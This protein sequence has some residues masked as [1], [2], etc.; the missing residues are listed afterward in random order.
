VAPI[1]IK[2]D[3]IDASVLA[4]LYASGF[5]PEIWPPDE[6]TQALRRQVGGETS[7]FAS[8]HA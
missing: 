5:L 1:T 8:A 3:R 6:R 7:W 4:R 2:T